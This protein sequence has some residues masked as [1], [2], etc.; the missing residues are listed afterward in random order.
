MTSRGRG[1]TLTT[2][3]WMKSDGGNA[4]P[5]VSRFSSN[6]S[7]HNDEQN[8]QSTRVNSGIKDERFE[9]QKA[10]APDG[11]PYWYTKDGRTSWT[12]PF[13]DD[14]RFEDA[15]ADLERGQDEKLGASEAGIEVQRSHL[16]SIW[17]AVRTSDGREYYYNIHTRET[18]WTRPNQVVQQ[19]GI[20][21]SELPEGWKSH[22]SPEGKIYYSHAATGKTQWHK[23]EVESAQKD[24]VD[25]KRTALEVENGVSEEQQKKKTRTNDAT[26]LPEGWTELKAED[27][28]SYYYSASTGVTSWTIPLD[29]GTKPSTS[30]D[31]IAPESRQNEDQS[32]KV[33]KKKT[34]G[35]QRP[36]SPSGRALSDREAEAFFLSE[37]EKRVQRKASTKPTE[38]EARQTEPVEIE[39]K[40]SSENGKLRFMKMLLK[41]R[42]TKE[43]RWLEAMK[44]CCGMPE[45]LTA[46]PSYGLRKDAFCAFTAQL[47]KLER[48]KATTDKRKLFLDFENMLAEYLSVDP[49]EGCKSL[50]DVSPTLAE[51][52]RRDQRYLG[53]VDDFERKSLV[54][55]FFSKR[56]TTLRNERRKQRESNMET[57]RTTLDLMFTQHEISERIPLR[58]AFDRCK[59]K[60]EDA[61]EAVQALSSEDLGKVY[62]M[63]R[64][65]AEQKAAARRVRE[66]EE[67]KVLERNARNAVRDGLLALISEG[68]ISISESY[69]EIQS[70]I[71]GESWAEDARRLGLRMH[72]IVDSTL[73][74]VE[75]EAKRHRPLFETALHAQGLDNIQHSR[76]LDLFEGESL[77]LDQKQDSIL[78]AMKTGGVNQAQARVLWESW[79]EGMAREA[80]RSIRKQQRII[81]EYKSLIKRKVMQVENW[82]EFRERYSNRTAF[83]ECFEHFSGL[84]KSKE[85]ENELTEMQKMFE[86]CLATCRSTGKADERK[87]KLSCVVDS[88]AELDE[89]KYKREVSDTVMKETETIDFVEREVFTNLEGA[90][91][92]EIEE[93]TRLENRR[94]E[95]EMRLKRSRTSSNK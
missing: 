58:D 10:Q 82:N 5:R 13:V 76:L 3:A 73:G 30:L 65:D 92:S 45:Y 43:T 2:P 91:P 9:W 48:A 78:N 42:I 70:I 75:Q 88:D 22:V 51:R 46:L 54:G 34:K 28:R 87:R 95:I 72:D 69:K 62:Q 24:T 25:R 77:E 86:E 23:P 16:D 37:L 18:S 67:R 80:K 38:T 53:I 27:G 7:T 26:T 57:L 84:H 93:L 89:K 52:I 79:R 94:I 8:V 1:R 20:D 15:E 33:D 63:W 59:T 40:T 41:A 47:R 6:N 61:A 50:D 12:S 32:R 71:S 31:R 19:N 11:R 85:T 4:P 64:R 56:D 29:S 68:R 44:R 66:R 14:E 21:Q 39:P 83:V 36:R 35:I 55:A 60:G 74:H 17:R 49:R 90:T 81:D